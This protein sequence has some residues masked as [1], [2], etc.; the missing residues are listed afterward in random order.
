MLA[1]ALAECAPGV[2]R[3]DAKQSSNQTLGISVTV[4]LMLCWL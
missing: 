2:Y 1:A 3:A 4:H